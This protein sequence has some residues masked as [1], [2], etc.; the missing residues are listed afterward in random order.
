MGVKYVSPHDNP[1]DPGGLI[2]EVLDLGALFTGPAE[3]TL[4]SW[5]LR[6]PPG[7]DATQAANNLLARYKLRE[8]PP[9]DG[10]T[11]KLIALIEQ[12]ASGELPRSRGR[13]GGWR[14]RRN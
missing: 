2:R 8:G 13:R 1:D 4:L 7:V 9:R 10:A 5:L 14:G 11:G 3:D 6:L 12:A